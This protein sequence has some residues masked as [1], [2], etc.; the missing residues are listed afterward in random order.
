MGRFFNKTA[1]I[2]PR[3]CMFLN[4]GGEKKLKIQKFQPKPSGD[5]NIGTGLWLCSRLL[6]AAARS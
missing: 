4:W 1:T 3:K 6:A 5:G 2:S